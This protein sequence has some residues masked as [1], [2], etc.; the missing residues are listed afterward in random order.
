MLALYNKSGHLLL[1]KLPAVSE[2]IHYCIWI[3]IV[4]VFVNLLYVLGS[5]QFYKSACT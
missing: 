2:K 1:S 4:R 5:M 3:A